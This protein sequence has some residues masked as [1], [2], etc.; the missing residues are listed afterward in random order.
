MFQPSRLLLLIALVPG[1]IVAA[2]PAN[3]WTTFR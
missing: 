3:F 1:I 2:V